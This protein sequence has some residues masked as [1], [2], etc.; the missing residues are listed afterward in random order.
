MCIR[1]S[2]TTVENGKA[3][4]E[5]KKTNTQHIQ[6]KI[7]KVIRIGTK[8]PESPKTPETPKGESKDVVS[9]TI[10]EIPFD[11]EIIQDD[12][13]ESGKVIEEQAGQKG[14]RKI[15]TTVTI[16]DGVSSEPKVTDVVTKEPVK[17]IVRV[18]TNKTPG[19]DT[20]ETTTRTEKIPFET[21]VI[22][23]NTLP[24]G[25]QVVLQEGEEGVRTITTTGDKVS[26]QITKAPKPRIVRIGTKKIEGNPTPRPIPNPIPSP[27]P[28]LSD[29]NIIDEPTRP[30]E[31]SNP[32]VEQPNQ[33]S[34]DPEL[35]DDDDIVD[36]DNTIDN[37]DDESTENV[38]EPAN[39]DDEI[40]D[41][42]PSDESDDNLIGSENDK[43]DSSDNDIAN[44]KEKRESEDQDIAGL[45]VPKRVEK[46]DS[47]KIT[48]SSTNPKTGIAGS[49]KV[50]AT[51]AGSLL[52]LFA[53]KKKKD[54][55]EE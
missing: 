7:D 1:D 46:I 34:S 24:E 22:Y 45:K 3:V 31:P 49:T 32:I 2:T 16:K 9:T 14:E 50:A 26:E 30:V 41:L 33:P 51:L 25:K 37:V 36:N 17:R 5:A 10:V 20:P 18:G 38:N 54:D 6:E 19:N 35:D 13:I 47:E 44:T 21:T 40:T 52:G 55:E 23:D 48:K 43:K 28:D 27:N 12:T 8:C 42:K 53:S 29:D 4:G 11:T 15:T 39:T